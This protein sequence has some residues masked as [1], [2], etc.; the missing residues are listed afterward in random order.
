MQ[1]EI[2]PVGRPLI[3]TRLID[4]LKQEKKK[5]SRAKRPNLVE[6]EDSESQF[7]SPSYVHRAKAFSNKK[8]LRNK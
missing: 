5:R 7:Y 2:C 3:I 1:N 6:E 4:A 8:R